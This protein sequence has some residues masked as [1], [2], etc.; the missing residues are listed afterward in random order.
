LGCRL[1]LWMV[2]SCVGVA[3]LQQ[4]GTTHCCEC[5]YERN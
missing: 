1:H 4:M 3:N 5:R 2:A